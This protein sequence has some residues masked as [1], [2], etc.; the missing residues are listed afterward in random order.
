MKEHVTFGIAVSLMELYG[1][2]GFDEYSLV[3]TFNAGLILLWD[4]FI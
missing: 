3:D 4:L 2:E 1:T